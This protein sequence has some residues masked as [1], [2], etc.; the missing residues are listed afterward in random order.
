ML[1]SAGARRGKRIHVI[2]Y[3]V[4]QK[5]CFV[6]QNERRYETV[7]ASLLAIKSAASR[8]EKCVT[9]ILWKTFPHNVDM[10]LKSALFFAGFLVFGDKICYNT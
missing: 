6:K 9:K 2:H 3:I 1:L 7:R 4:S 10:L 8:A 5:I